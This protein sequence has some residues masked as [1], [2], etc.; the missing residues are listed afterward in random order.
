VTLLELLDAF[1]HARH[2]SETYQLMEKQR[3]EEKRRLWRKARQRMRGTAHEDHLEEDIMTLWEKI[4]SMNKETMSLVTLCGNDS[5]DELIKTF[6][7]VLFL[8]NEGKVHVY[9]KHFPF[10]K[11]FIKNIGCS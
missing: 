6:M 11:I 1:D 2:E 4:R 8:A 9:Q 3:N 5:R 10:G 7:S